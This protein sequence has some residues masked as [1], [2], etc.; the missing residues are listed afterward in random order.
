MKIHGE[1]HYIE[2]DFQ[3]HQKDA[4]SQPE[5]PKAREQQAP[6]DRLE[7]SV[8]GK[9]LQ[10]LTRVAPESAEVR[11]RRVAAIKAQVEAG[12]YNIRAEE[13]AEA[14]ITGSLIDRSV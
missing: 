10:H 8:T 2:R 1:N 13:V 6:R 12:T 7:F 4:A 14:M 9:E 5:T 3:I 11:A